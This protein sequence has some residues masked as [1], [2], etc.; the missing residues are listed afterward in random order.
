MRPR[1]HRRWMIPL[2]AARLDLVHRG[3]MCAR[4]GALERYMT[5]REHGE[6]VALA[7]HLATHRP[8][9]VSL[10]DA[11]LI[12]EARDAAHIALAEVRGLAE[13]PEGPAARAAGHLDQV[14]RYLTRELMA[15]TERLEQQAREPVTGEQEREA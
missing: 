6:L 9:V 1:G 4:D 15:R 12:I 5:R 10:W 8:R 3:I 14:A 11:R 13:A 7:E 2:S